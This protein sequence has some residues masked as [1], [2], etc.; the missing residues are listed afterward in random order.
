MRHYEILRRL[1]AK[2]AAELFEAIQA[3]NADYG[4]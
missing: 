1:D 3:N 2:L 4:E